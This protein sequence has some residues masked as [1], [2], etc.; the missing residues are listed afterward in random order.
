MCAL[1]EES[2]D[3]ISP[4]QAK[5]IFLAGATEQSYE[6]ANKQIPYASAYGIGFTKTLDAAIASAATPVLLSDTP[7]PGKDSPN[8]IVRNTSRL[9][10]CDLP[11]P[12]SATTADVKAI[13]KSKGALVIDPAL[14]L[15]GAKTCPAV[16]ANTNVYRDY[17]HISVATSLRLEPYIASKLGA[18][19][20][21]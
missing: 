9:S 19:G 16:F 13:A 5:Y 15:C 10:K 3:G 21:D 17:S 11:L 8:C 4:L 1:G 12:H 2:G 7:W 18:S 6:L 14:V 20:R